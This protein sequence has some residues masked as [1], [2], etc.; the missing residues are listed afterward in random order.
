MGPTE[1]GRLTPEQLRAGLNTLAPMPGPGGPGGFGGP[2]GGGP[3]MVPQN[4]TSKRNGM[5]A[6]S[7]IDFE[8]VHADLDFEGTQFRDVAVRYKGNNSYMESRNSIKK[9]LKLDLN[10]YVKGQKLAGLTKLNLHNNVTDA[11]WMNEPLSTG[12][13][14]T[15]RRPLA[16]HLLC[17]RFRDRTRQ[18]RP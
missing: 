14:A 6:M 13:S 7:G 8:Y 10:K 11:S 17:P 15:R 1:D 18:V 2:G 16:A 4:G 9:S 12:C 5:S 3:G